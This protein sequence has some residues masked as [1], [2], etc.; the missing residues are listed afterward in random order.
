MGIFGTIGNLAKGLGKAVT[1]PGR[2]ALKGVQ[3][4]PGVKQV[5]RLA[6]DLAPIAGFIPG[7]GTLAGGIAGAGGAALAGDSLG[8][9][10]KKGALGAGGAALGGLVSGGSLGNLSGIGGL[11]QKTFT[12]PEGGLDLEKIISLGGGAAQ[13]IGQNKQRGENQAFQ[14]GVFDANTGAL[15]GS[16]EIAG[17]SAAL[18]PQAIAAVQAALRPRSNTGFVGGSR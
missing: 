15:R 4:I 3:Q 16:E 11:L 7:L 10:L 9:V 8:D 1:A 5:G 18:N 14:Q 13:L 6:S 12:T 17:Q 2:L